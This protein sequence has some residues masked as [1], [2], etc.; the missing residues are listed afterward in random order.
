MREE[1]IVRAGSIELNERDLAI[2]NAFEADEKESIKGIAKDNGYLGCSY[3][4][5]IEISIVMVEKAGMRRRKEVITRSAPL[6]SDALVIGNKGQAYFSRPD[7]T[8]YF[9]KTSNIKKG[10]RITGFNIESEWIAVDLE[11]I[12]FDGEAAGE[13]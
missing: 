8:W 1:N 3:A 2:L 4:G 12:K 13:E 5:E 11:E 10:N 6:N 7:G 9:R